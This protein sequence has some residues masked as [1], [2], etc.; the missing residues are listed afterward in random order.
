MEG[1]QF[2]KIHLQSECQQVFCKPLSWKVSFS[3]ISQK[4]YCINYDAAYYNIMTFSFEYFNLIF[5]ALAITSN[6]C[7]KLKMK[8]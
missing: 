7:T 3:N 6:I 1:K 2:N 4:T 5:S 8:S